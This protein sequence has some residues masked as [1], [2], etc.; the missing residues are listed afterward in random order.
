MIPSEHPSVPAPRV[1]VLLVN[2]GTPDAPTPSAVRRYLAEFLS[3][4]RVVEIPQIVW[5]PILRGIILRTRPK[6]SAHAYEEIW[7]KDGSPLI[8]TS[9]RVRDKLADKLGKDTPVY[10]AM[11]YGNPSIASV[12]EKIAA[13]GI[14][15]VL[16]FPQYPHY[17]MSSWETVVVKVYA[18]AARL[19]PARACR[20]R[21]PMKRSSTPANGS[22]RS[23]PERNRCD[24]SPDSSREP[25]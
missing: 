11:R 14:E 1:G 24:R 8:L 13:D 9:R 18:E 3:D 25:R 15:E 23:S 16:L 7:T 20:R 6:R 4:P 22:M 12:I 19:A 2:L 17:A 5:Q 21:I 10:L